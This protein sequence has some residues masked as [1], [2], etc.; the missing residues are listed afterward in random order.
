MIYNPFVETFMAVLG[1]GAAVLV[2]SL[3]MCAIILV[4]D[5]VYK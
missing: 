1:A 3:V 2:I 5:R 4:I